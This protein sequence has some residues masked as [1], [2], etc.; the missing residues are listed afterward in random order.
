MPAECTLQLR[1][2]VVEAQPKIGYSGLTTY[3]PDFSIKKLKNE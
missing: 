1:Y 3:L 2:K